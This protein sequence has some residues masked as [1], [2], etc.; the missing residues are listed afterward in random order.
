MA[1][2]DQSKSWTVGSSCWC[3]RG[4][5]SLSYWCEWVQLLTRFL[6]GKFQLML[7]KAMHVDGTCVS[8]L[9]F[10]TVPGIDS[11]GTWGAGCCTVGTD[12]MPGKPTQSSSLHALGQEMRSPSFFH[13]AI[14][15]ASKFPVGVVGNIDWFG[16]TWSGAWRGKGAA[17]APLPSSIPVQSTASTETTSRDGAGSGILGGGLFHS[18]IVWG[19]MFDRIFGDYALIFVGFMEERRFVKRSLTDILKSFVHYRKCLW[20]FFNRLV[21]TISSHYL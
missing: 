3:E 12:C 2:C 18:L 15:E 17:C 16:M 20:I 10:W 5:T 6:W 21:R 14:H 9:S 11:S 1:G 4:C 19:W 7:V 13:I 8:S